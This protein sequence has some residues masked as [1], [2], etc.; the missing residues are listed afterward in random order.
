MILLTTIYPYIHNLLCYIIIIGVYSRVSDLWPW[1][2]ETACGMSNDVPDYFDCGDLPRPPTG[3]PTSTLSPTL[4]QTE[5]LLKITLDGYPEEFGWKIRRADNDDIVH[6]RFPGEYT[7]QGGYR[8]RITVDDGGTFYLD[9]TDDRNDGICCVYG[10]GKVE[11]F[12]GGESDP[13]MLLAYSNGEY[14]TSASIEFTASED[15]V[16]EGPGGGPGEDDNSPKAAFTVRIRTDLY[17]VESSWAIET[18]ER[19]TVFDMAAGV[20]TTVN[21]DVTQTIELT[22]GKTYNF[23][24]EDSFGDGICKFISTVHWM[25]ARSWC[26]RMESN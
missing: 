23:V 22:L 18:Q 14:G 16:I 20:I 1:I 17:P 5:V 11:L 19:Q 4:T 15:A 6:E 8:E 13:D 3:A 12:L 9:L 7:E 10:N 26:I 24:I 21:G 2:R 25:S